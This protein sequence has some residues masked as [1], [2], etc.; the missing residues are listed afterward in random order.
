M[1]LNIGKRRSF[2]VSFPDFRTIPLKSQKKENAEFKFLYQKEPG[3]F[4]P[5]WFSDELQ[6]ILSISYGC[7]PLLSSMYKIYLCFSKSKKKIF[8]FKIISVWAEKINPLCE[9]QIVIVK[10]AN[11]FIWMIN[12]QSEGVNSVLSVQP[13]FV[14][15]KLTLPW[16]NLIRHLS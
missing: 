9:I 16:L 3:L 11:E 14:K 8:F 15:V 10:L 2:Q 4:I 12:R 5:I 13:D 7:K 6:F 1:I